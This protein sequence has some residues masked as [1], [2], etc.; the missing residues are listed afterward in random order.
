MLHNQVAVFGDLKI[1]FKVVG[2]AVVRVD[3]AGE[4]FFG[5][6]A[7]GAAMRDDQRSLL[8]VEVL[9]L[10]ELGRADLDAAGRCE[11]FQGK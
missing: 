6:V 10:G 1:H 3:E 2:A 5:G 7:E 4:G 9:G 11:Q 8:I